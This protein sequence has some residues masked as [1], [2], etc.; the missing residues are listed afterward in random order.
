MTTANFEVAP[1]VTAS[2]STP[3][4]SWLGSDGVKSTAPVQ[5]TQAEAGFPDI[6]R[7]N[8]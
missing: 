8:A 2:S 1:G 7:R 6:G 3:V 4:I 5:A